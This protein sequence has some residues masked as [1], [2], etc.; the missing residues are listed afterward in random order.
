MKVHLD[1]KVAMTVHRRILTKDRVVYLL[2][3]KKSF[4]YKGGRSQIA[5]I[6]T[7][8]RGAKRIASSAA[9]K[10]E[11]VF[12]KW[13]SKDME[14]YIASCA[15][16]PGLP[17]WKYLER[18]LLTEFVNNYRELPFC[19][20]QGEKFRF[21]EKLHKLFKQKRIYRLLMRFDA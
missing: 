18:A 15:A 12:S 14:V 10:A 9:N 11:E 4:T 3:G 1:S 7:S 21:N 5:Y 19:N 16:R 6:G 2:V 8:K 17:S 13:G 20:K